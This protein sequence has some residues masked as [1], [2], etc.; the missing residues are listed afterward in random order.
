MWFIVTRHVDSHYDS[1]LLIEWNEEEDGKTMGHQRSAGSEHGMT[2]Y[3]DI[4]T[5]VI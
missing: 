4:C 2:T 1:E 3:A 5:I